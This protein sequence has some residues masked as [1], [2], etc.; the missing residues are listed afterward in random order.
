LRISHNLRGYG[1][2]IYHDGR[3]YFWHAHPSCDFFRIEESVIRTLAEKHSVSEREKCGQRM[4]WIKIA[5][6]MEGTRHLGEEYL[7]EIVER[8]GWLRECCLT[9]STLLGCR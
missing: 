3:K 1:R 7:G 5:S 4:A 9:V 6:A 2:L 8:L